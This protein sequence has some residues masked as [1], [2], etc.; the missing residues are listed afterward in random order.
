MADGRRH[1]SSVI[2]F[3][4][5]GGNCLLRLLLGCCSC[6]KCDW[7]NILKV[8][9]N[10]VRGRGACTPLRSRVSIIIVTICFSIFLQQWQRHAWTCPELLWRHL[11]A[12]WP[13]TDPS[14]IIWWNQPARLTH[15]PD[16][17][18]QN[19]FLASRQKRDFSCK[20]SRKSCLKSGTLQTQISLLRAPNVK[21]TFR[22]HLKSSFKT[23]V[24]RTMCATCFCLLIKISKNPD[25]R[26]VT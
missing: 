13:E 1:E 26:N 10:T 2:V 19:V 6:S 15:F 7:L 11:E 24:D 16:I 4:M 5:K 3:L 12:R 23:P 18:S 21:A 9:D 22:D 25:V 8:L 20:K 17:S 14:W